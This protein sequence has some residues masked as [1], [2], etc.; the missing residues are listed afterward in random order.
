MPELHA[1]GWVAGAVRQGLSARQGL[2]EFRDHGGKI[3]D[4]TWNKIYAEQQ[5]ATA[6]MRAEMQR[7]LRSVPR[8]D[9]MTA[10]TT[11]R[12]QGYL[13]T[14][15]IYT[16]IKGTDVVTTRAFMFSGQELM[17]RGDALTKALTMMQ[18]AVDE[19][20]YEETIL[21][22]V[23]TGTRVMVPGETS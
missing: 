6:A 9:E 16:R 14:L 23:Y 3:R 7:D 10:M 20:R 21:G 2:R 5:A 4:S 1:P 8:A 19:E 13:Q 22:G 12:A 11:K 18:Q 17:S 15:D